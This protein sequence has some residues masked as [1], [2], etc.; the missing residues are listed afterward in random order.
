MPSSI[1]ETMAV[2]IQQFADRLPDRLEAIR[3]QFERIDPTAWHVDEA[4][5]LQ[6]LVHGLTGAA[7]TFGMPSVSDAARRLQTCLDAYINQAPTASAWQEVAGELDNL[8]ATVQARLGSGTL[9]LKQPS[10]LLLLNNLSPLI[11][12]VED[13]SEQADYLA[14]ALVA[15][16]FRVRI[17]SS[18][19]EFRSAYDANAAD[20]PCAIVMDMVFPDGD[21]AGADVIAELGQV[22]T[23]RVPVLFVSV[24]NDLTARLAAYRAGAVRYLVKPVDGA[25]L[26]RLL[27]EV[28][29]RLPPEPYRILLV[30]DD[31]ALLD[32]YSAILRHAGLQVEAVSQ[33][34]RA[35]DALDEFKPDV[36]VLDVYMPDIS[37]PEL[38]AVLREQETYSH[39]PILFLSAEVNVDK[40]LLALDLG[41]DDFLVKPITP[42][43]LILA[44]VAR[45]RRARRN[46]QTTQRLQLALYEREREHLALDRH[47]LVSIT[48]RTGKIIY[49]NDTFCSVSGH[50]LNALLGQNHRIIK[51]GLHNP[52]FYSELWSVISGGNIWRGEICNKDRD[53]SLFWT[54]VTI[55][56]FLDRFGKIYRYV[57][58]RTDITKLKRT[59]EN[60][61]ASTIRLKEAEIQANTREASTRAILRTMLDGVVHINSQGIILSVNDAVLKMFGYDED[62]LIGHNVSL[63]M[64]EHHAKAHDGHLRRYL[65]TRQAHVVGKRIERDGRRRNGQLFPIELAINEMVDDEGSTFIGVISDITERKLAKEALQMAVR[66]AD[67]AN[68]AKS[69]FLSSMSHE[70][71]TPLNA[72]LGFAQML[73]CS[74]KLDADDQ[75][76]T[77]EIL[78][79]GRHLLNLINE[80]LDLAKI[81]AGRVEL[82]LEPVLLD[83][84]VKDCDQLIR[85]LANQRQLSLRF[86]ILPN[87][88]VRADRIRLKQV[89]LNLLSN[90]VK[91]NRDAGFIHLEVLPAANRRLR[92]C[93][94]DNGIGI[95]LERRAALF[96]PFSR[97]DTDH[98]GIEGTGIGL[99]ITRRLVTMMDGSVGVDHPDAG[100]SVF[101]IEL[102]L[103]CI[104]KSANIAMDDTSSSMD[105][106]PK[107]TYEVLYIDD[108]PSNLKLVAQLLGSRKHIHLR[109]TLSPQQGI[110]LAQSHA[111]DLILLD[112]SMPEMDG[113]Q[114]FDVLKADA[115]LHHIP[116]I[117][118]SANA[119]QRDIERSRSAGFSDYLT[120]PIDVRHFL[121]TIDRHLLACERTQ[122]HG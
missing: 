29:G 93:V 72:I 74:E 9:S 82:S 63:L 17:F 111:P 106:E 86:D 43:H 38:A 19:E 52:E 88:I 96:D 78:K 44:V 87:S 34:L 33:P 112:I 24:R 73:E 76:S 64:P 53:G 77:Q 92:I 120:K 6:R 69:E 10:G 121:Q 59:Q 113:Y 22:Q 5:H 94:T 108:N 47:A 119:M 2:L 85:P 21:T 3:K 45:A 23:T 14:N 1:N 15:N 18:T 25:Q 58:I 81:E 66:E 99:T 75:D 11:F 16:N 89:L 4:R 104:D 28:T 48:D 42:E 68:R 39:T 98:R 102:P 8:V 35:L 57:A 110:A 56:P 103:T 60:L 36:V 7:G 30:D 50:S 114:V 122:S 62:E 13:D 101:W 61:L 91:Y 40:Q 80:I 116:V 49:A 90:A 117:A 83:E 20:R 12:L 109:T 51:S 105:G 84:L 37:G 32:A 79:A 97:I 46:A 41:G 115:K 107:R 55:T 27:D 118:L 70:L 65:Q 100:G 26:C 95:P 31:V 67:R 54:N 71:R